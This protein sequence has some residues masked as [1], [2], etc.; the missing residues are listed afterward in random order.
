MDAK[1]KLVA[2]T[3]A[4]FLM[5]ANGCGDRTELSVADDREPTAGGVLVSD[6]ESL[7]KAELAQADREF[8]RSVR[9]TGLEGWIAA[10][11]ENGRVLP[12]DGPMVTGP[13]AI[14]DL[15]TPLFSKPG[16]EITWA[17]AG[18]EVAASGDLGY[19]Y[20]HWKT[21][22]PTVGAGVEEAE[23]KYV[24]IWG[25]DSEGRWRVLLDIGNTQPVTR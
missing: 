18:A 7:L 12:A 13:I 17:P 5:L 23:G 10:F 4:G 14:R 16:F 19:T 20:G 3:A 25:R 21:S 2:L 1:K 11:A 8:A 15:F 24:T 9:D 22:M 6:A